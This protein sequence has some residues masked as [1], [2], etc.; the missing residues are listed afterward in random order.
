MELSLT[1]FRKAYDLNTQA[2]FW[3]ML[4]DWSGSDVVPALCKDLCEVE[5]GSKC[6]H[7]CPSI[8]VRMMQGE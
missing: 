5:Q 1:E 8:V 6:Q 4:S 2:D 7:G 3:D